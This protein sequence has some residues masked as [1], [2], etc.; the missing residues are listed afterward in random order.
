MFAMSRVHFK[1]MLRDG[2]EEKW[3]S[4]DKKWFCTESTTKVPGLLKISIYKCIL[5]TYE[6]ISSG[7]GNVL[8]YLHW[9][10]SQMLYSWREKRL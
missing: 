3:K 2:M 6:T 4:I 5:K 8:R 1:D 7:K 9:S 10:V